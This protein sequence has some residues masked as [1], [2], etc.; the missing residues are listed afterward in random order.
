MDYADIYS[1]GPYCS[2]ACTAAWGFYGWV[3]L[4]AVLT[5]ILLVPEVHL[6]LIPGDPFPTIIQSTFGWLLFAF[7]ALIGWYCSFLGYRVRRNDD[8]PT[9]MALEKYDPRMRA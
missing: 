7:P 3:I 2:V 9:S 6:L 8:R 4:A 5:G 1:L